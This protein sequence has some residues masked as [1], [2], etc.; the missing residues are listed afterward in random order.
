[1]GLAHSPKIITDNLVLCLDAANT[2]SY[3]GSGTTWTDLSGEGNN[4]TISGATHTS[5]AGGYLEF[6]GT[7]DVVTVS[8]TS[9]FAYT[10]G[11]FTWDIWI[12]VDSLTNNTYALDH[13]SNGGTLAFGGGNGNRYYNTT[14]GTSSTLF[15]TGFG[16]ISLNQWYHLVA[17]RISGTT[18]L[19]KNASLTTSASDSHNYAAQA[20]NIGKW[21]GNNYYWDG[22]ISSS[23]IYKGKGLTAIEVAQNFNA[24]RGRYGI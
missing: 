6:D 17:S 14:T 19:Y 16:T 4:G 24:L 18:Y 1:M 5:G 9:D 12:N 22:K 8:S 10:T 13:G 15:T 20:L 21:G 3:G 11:D 7:N 23:K 2:K